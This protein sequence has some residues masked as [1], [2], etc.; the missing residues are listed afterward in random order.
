MRIDIR[1]VSRLHGPGAID[2]PAALAPV[3]A[4]LADAPVELATLRVVCDWIQYRHNFAE[5][6]TARPV[7]ADRHAAAHD[8]LEIGI[9]LRR[10]GET[11]LAT[12]VK[13]VL[14]APAD[15]PGKVVLETWRPA[16]DS[17]IWQFNTLYW[18]ALSSWERATGRDYEQALPGGESD[19][20][21][22][23]AVREMILEL[24]AVWDEL[25]ASPVGWPP[26]A[27]VL[28]TG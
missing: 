26:R 9:D 19:A 4:A 16:R 6:V 15:S 20:R 22:T 28:V 1:P 24:F 2:V 10:S 25:A 13:Q 17:C 14:A 23:Q 21:N 7:L 8:T 11:D 3:F 5:P 12:Q 27:V 18:Q